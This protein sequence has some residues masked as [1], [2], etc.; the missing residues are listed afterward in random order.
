MIARRAPGAGLLLLA[1]AGAC[2]PMWWIF[3][4]PQLVVALAVAI[5][6]GGAIATLGA[7]RRWS[8]PRVAVLG[9]AALALLAVPLTAPQ[10]IPRG[11]SLAAFLDAGAAVVLSWRRLLTIGLP[12]GTG[13]S[14]LMAPVVLALAGTI[15]GVSIALRSRR[16]EAAALVPAVIAVWSILWGPHDLPAPWLSGVLA[17][18]PLTAY[19]TVVRQAR[20]R[21]R[22]PRALSSLARR[23]G[24][25][26]IV[27]LLAGGGAAAA[28]ALLPVPDRVVLR[29][30]SPSSVALEGHSPLSAY[31]AN[32][33]ADTRDAVQLTAT[34]LEPGD[35]IRVAALDDYDGEVLGVGR[36]SFERVPGAEGGQGRVVGITVDGF[37]SAWLPTVG[38]PS[39]I[40]FIGPRAEA[41]AS[42]LHRDAA[43]GALVVTPG[44]GAG[45]GY[46][47]LVEPGTRVAEGDEVRGLEPADPLLG[48]EAL[49][50]AM[51]TALASWTGEASSPGDRLAAMVEAL[52]AQGYVSHGV[53]DDEAPSRAGHSIERLEELFREPMI[54]DAEQYATAAMLLARQLGFDARVVVG[55]TPDAIAPGSP[56]VVV[57]ADADAWIE[58]RSTSGW[59]GIDVVPEPRPIPEQEDGAPTVVEEPP[60]Q[61]APAPPPGGQQQ[62]V[63]PAA[64]SAPQ[65]TDDPTSRLLAVLGAAA[66]VLGLVALVAALPVGLV[67]AK[68][69]RRRRRR[70]AEEPRE[71]A[72]GAWNELVDRLRDRGDAPPPDGTR[73]EQAGA[74]ER[75]RALADR[76]DRAVFAAAP[77]TDAEVDEAWRLS[78]DVLAARDADAG[79]MRPA[80]ASLNPAS[81]VGR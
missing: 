45:D 47:L 21:S 10:R 76:V 22:A 34:G 4:T 2:V 19:V 48:T 73:L 33:A 64:P 13:D 5:L 25:G 7:W 40:R 37:E 71:R 79:R 65:D 43:L 23:V 72:E 80:L 36:A 66:A 35:R 55:F 78:D 68:V 54:G 29:G 12:V 11:D 59:V 49:P 3:G 74:D 20:R 24:A 77:P 17:L 53:L 8:W 44:I 67:I 31:R 26:G 16:G 41:L 51:L 56:T 1:I 50:D 81:L 28:G 38:V 39:A 61:Q 42:G 6:V 57:G 52:R 63:D 14:L 30:D 75:M 18:V 58:V 69:V 9:V 32:W 27:A 46:Q 70:R 15:I 60:A 62:G